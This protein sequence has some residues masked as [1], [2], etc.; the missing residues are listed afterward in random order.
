MEDLKIFK[1]AQFV[2]LT[3][4]N[5]AY[6][7][8][9]TE[10]T[11]Y[12]GY[13]LDNWIATRAVRLFTERWRKKYKK[14]PRHWLV[15]EL[16]EGPTEHLHIH[17]LIWMHDKIVNPKDQTLEPKEH[18]LQSLWQ[19]GRTDIGEY[20]NERTINYITKYVTK[21]DPKHKHYKPV[22][23]ASKGLG[24]D[25]LK[26]HNATLN[27]Y[28]PNETKETYTTKTGHKIALPP[29]YKNKIYKDEEKEKLWI[30]KLDKCERF[31]MGTKVDTSQG[32]TELLAA[33]KQ[34]KKINREMGYGGHFNYKEAENEIQRRELKQQERGVI[35]DLIT[36][37]K[38]GREIPDTLTGEEILMNYRAREEWIELKLKHERNIGWD[39]I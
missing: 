15:T 23:L 21:V 34:A 33:L 30:E 37:P 3:F 7:K 24:A 8:I 36:V 27:K 4:S 6:A 25:Y 20:V 35:K 38:Y 31:I 17:G 14:A 32:D 16:G 11:Y 29:Y 22:V 39:D 1:N 12:E 9:A 10:N 13:Y 19:Y 5:E 26:S 18:V 2:T 28:K